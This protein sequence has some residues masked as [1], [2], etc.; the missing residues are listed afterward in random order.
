MGVGVKSGPAAAIPFELRPHRNGQRLRQAGK[1]NAGGLL[2][3]KSSHRMHPPGRRRNL[4]DQFARAFCHAHG[5]LAAS[6]P[7]ASGDRTAEARGHRRA[8]VQFDKP[9]GFF[10]H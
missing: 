9:P 7:G 5:Q 1:Q 3:G 2:V 6:S 8:A 10:K 4:A